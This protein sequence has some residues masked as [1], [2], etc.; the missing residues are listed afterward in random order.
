MTTLP[1]EITQLTNLIIFNLNSNKLTGLPLDFFRLRRLKKLE[2]FDNKL[3]ELPKEIGDM[4]KL[5]ILNLGYNRIKNLP[6]EIGKL[7]DLTE[8]YIYNNQLVD[9]PREIGQLSKL[10]TLDLDTNCLTILPSEIGNLDTLEILNISYN[11]LTSLP[12]EIGKLVNLTFLDISFNSLTDLPPEIRNK[13]WMGIFNFLRQQLEQDVDYLYEAKFLIIG[14]PGAGKTTLAQKIKN[15]SYILK[16][17]EESTEG[18]DV[19]CFSFPLDNGKKFQINIW[20]FGGQEI[21]HQTHQFFLTSRSLYT[22]VA[23]SRKEDT[24][25]YYWLNIVELLSNNSPL[26]IIK[27]EKQDRQRDI[28]EKKLRGEFTNLKEIIATNL[29]TNRGL[30]TILKQVKHYIQSLPH[31]GDQLPAYWVKVREILEKD[32]RNYISLDEF[33]TVCKYQGFKSLED[34]L[35]LSG[36]LHDLGIFLH[37][38]KDDLLQKTIVLKPTWGT[39]AVYRV[40]DTPKVRNNLGKFSRLDLENI[41][42]EEQYAPMRSELLR[43]MMKFKLC[44]EIPSSPNHYIAP[45][46]LSADRAD[47][48]W[49][50][51]DNLLLRCEYEFMPKGILTRFIVEMHRWIEN[52]N[53]VWKTGVVLK[54]EDARAEIVELYRYHKG[55]IQIRV[56]GKRKRDLLTTVRHELGKIHDS[57]E[58]LKYK[59]LV[60][61]N[62]SECKDNQSPYFYDWDTINR[63][64]DKNKKTIECQ[65]SCKDVN[66]LRLVNDTTLSQSPFSLNNEDNPMSKNFNAQNMQYIENNYSEV[67][68]N[69]YSSDSDVKQSVDKILEM[70]KQLAQKYPN[71][72]ETEAENIV[73]V[74]FTT[75]QTQNPKQW[76][77]ITQNL[78][79]KERW[80]QGGKAALIA[81][82]DHYLDKSVIYKAGLAFLDK[83]SEQP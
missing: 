80:L 52:E 73:N 37:F 35:V 74:E 64:L 32:S 40:L 58:R 19:I 63:Y 5:T 57:Y 1:P 44:Y 3:T 67:N 83:F 45:Q 27:N 47:Y 31:V 36:Y 7:R 9:L 77:N 4:S 50:D 11:C 71:I 69:K 34:I 68:W 41:W 24:D 76:Q 30:E 59:T 79:N 10:I 23:D 42:Q 17:D 55:E 6:N 43:L 61:C 78:L 39:D 70:L 72:T 28:N 81:T 53:L 20:D 46:L 62:C 75:L 56:M 65:I 2:I 8:F 33:I 60:P 13:H 48:D 66:I 49:D 25:F 26:L 12:L 29:A 51:Q 22:L 82:T 18:I 38:Q 16:N 14:E 15:P 54:K 21:Y